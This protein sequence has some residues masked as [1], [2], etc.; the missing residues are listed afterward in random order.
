MTGVEDY[1]SVICTTDEGLLAYKQR[2]VAWTKL[3]ADLTS[4]SRCET[5]D[6]MWERT[7]RCLQAAE[8]L[9]RESREDFGPYT[10][11]LYDESVCRTV[12]LITVCYIMLREN[13]MD[14]VRGILVRAS[15]GTDV[16]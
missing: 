14:H 7:M 11:T 3:Y 4:P 5:V 15:D 16:H 2:L 6:D 1:L 10:A 9:A 8:A 13:L 12:A